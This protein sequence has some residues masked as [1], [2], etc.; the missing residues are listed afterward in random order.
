MKLNAF[1]QSWKCEVYSYNYH[2]KPSFQ[3][4]FLQLKDVPLKA[5]MKVIYTQCST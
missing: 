2:F 1:Q 4:D 3:N 5:D